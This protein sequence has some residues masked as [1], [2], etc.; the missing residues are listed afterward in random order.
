M[1]VPATIAAARSWLDR[2]SSRERAVESAVVLFVWAVSRALAWRAGVRFDA[3]LLASAWHL[4]SFESLR[5]DL[6]RSLFYLHVQ[7]PFVNAILGVALK[8][9]G[10]RPERLLALLSHAYGVVLAL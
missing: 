5:Q 9:S 8:I 10:G 7:P 6:A 2:P 1:S 4:V 3:S